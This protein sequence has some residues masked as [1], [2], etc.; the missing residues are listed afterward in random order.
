[1]FVGVRVIF[2]FEQ[3]WKNIQGCLSS[4]LTTILLCVKFALFKPATSIKAISEPPSQFVRLDLTHHQPLSDQVLQHCFTFTSR[5]M[6][7]NV[8]RVTYRS[9][10]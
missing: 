10:L 2:S 9:F 8:V 1:M 7:R 4:I 5:E 6:S 3:L